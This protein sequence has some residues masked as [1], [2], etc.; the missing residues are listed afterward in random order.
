MEHQESEHKRNRTSISFDG[1]TPSSEKAS[2]AARGS[3]RKADTK[4][5]RFLRAE[6]WDRGFRYLKNDKSVKG[7]PD[8]VFRAAR[9]VVFCDGDFWHGKDWSRRKAKLSRGN[10]PRYWLRKIERNIERD[11]QIDRELRSDGWI[12]LRFWESSIINDVAHVADL[13]AETVRGT[14]RCRLE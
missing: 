5:E 9:V 8:I 14:R 11:R 12:V 6:L 2:R 3:S 7:K 13:V 10:N 1:C 4:P